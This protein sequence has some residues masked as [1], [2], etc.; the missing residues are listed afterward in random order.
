MRLDNELQDVATL[1]DELGSNLD[2]YSDRHADIRLALKP[3]A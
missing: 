1:M 2:E 3:L